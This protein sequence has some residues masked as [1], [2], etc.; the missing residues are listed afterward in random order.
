[1][2]VRDREDV[3]L[4]VKILCVLGRALRLEC[5]YSTEWEVWALVLMRTSAE[6]LSQALRAS[7]YQRYPLY[8]NSSG[9]YLQSTA[10]P[11]NQAQWIKSSKVEM[12]LQR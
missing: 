7:D 1:M 9:F 5:N 2:E 11:E 8:L 4:R 6:C 3:R 12:L 10:D